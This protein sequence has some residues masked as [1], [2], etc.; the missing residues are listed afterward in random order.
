MWPFNNKKDTT[1]D[2]VLKNH[3]QETL[4]SYAEDEESLRDRLKAQYPSPES[5]IEDYRKGYVTDEQLQ[6]L[7]TGGEIEYIRKECEERDAEDT[8]LP[9]SLV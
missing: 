4:S 3:A 6:K 1:N 7:F 2:P 8:A 5:A 9:T